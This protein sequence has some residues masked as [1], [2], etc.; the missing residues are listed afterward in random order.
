MARKKHKFPWDPMIGKKAAMA[1]TGT[2]I[3]YGPT[4]SR[5]TKVVVSIMEAAQ[6]DEVKEMQKWLSETVDAR[7][8]KII[9]KKIVALLRKHAVTSVATVDRIL[10]CP[11]EEDIDYPSGEA[12]PQCPYW[13]GR[14]RFTG[15]LED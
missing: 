8:N 7:R 4:S 12:C 6:S 9:H 3:F 2:I 13:A 5:A 10:G 1:N 11:H 15:E 14:N